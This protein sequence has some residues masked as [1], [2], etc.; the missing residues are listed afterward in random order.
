[1][2]D[3][4]L[5][6]LEN[7]WIHLKKKGNWESYLIEIQDLKEKIEFMRF[8]EKQLLSEFN[9]RLEE[10][11]LKRVT[12]FLETKMCVGEKKFD[13]GSGKGISAATIEF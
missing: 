7:E 12:E 8:R 4:N 2:L 3:E 1:M 10:N 9:Y 11:K 13:Y 6:T 5:L